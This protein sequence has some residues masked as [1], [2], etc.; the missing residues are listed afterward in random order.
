MSK[1]S[2]IRDR[3]RQRRQRQQLT[4][5][6]VAFGVVLIVVA[7]AI[8]PYL[9][10]VGEIITPEL[11]ERPMADG[12]AMGDPNAPV[13]MEEYS[14]YQCSYCRRFSEETEPK[15][16]EQYVTTGKIYIV[17]KNFALSPSSV[18]FAEAALC[19]AEQNKFWEYHDILFANQSTSDP[20]KYSER[21][22]QG[23]AE[24]V[25]LDVDGFNQ[26]IS[27]RRYQDEVQRLGVEAD[28][29]GI[30]STPTF[31]INGKVILGAQPLEVF[32]QEIE[33]ALAGR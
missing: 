29:A 9:Q 17:F 15:L 14:D 30:D 22:L 20:N 7:I 31:I 1:R 16:V 8:L 25:G 12:A 19:A 28:S 24:A 10:P 32:Q 21:R 5:G 6:L 3:R 33:A 23:Y 11:I 26:C 13:I 4:F 18:P 27:K 2:E